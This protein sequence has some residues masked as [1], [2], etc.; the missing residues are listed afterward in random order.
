MIPHDMR[1]SCHEGSI[2]D[3][4]ELWVYDV[5]QRRWITVSL[6]YPMSWLLMGR[7]ALDEVL[8]EEWEKVRD[9]A[10]GLVE[11][12]IDKVVADDIVGINV[13]D[14]GTLTFIN[15]L[16]GYDHNVS[17]YYPPLAEYQLPTGSVK[18]VLRSEITELE[19]LSVHVDLVSYPGVEKGV[20]KYSHHHKGYGPMWQQIHIHARLPKHP[21]ILPLECL[22]LEEVS[23]TRVV[24]FTA[25]FIAGND[26]DTNKDRLFKLKH[27]RQLMQVNGPLL[28]LPTAAHRK[29][30]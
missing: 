27:L 5:D 15:K 21:N 19:R 28:V 12:H 4:L 30:T 8:D 20:F 25:P 11:E 1:F 14:S 22:V 26:L 16:P 2:I 3:D 13:D 6:A 29:L 24:G 18:T 9:K 7:E 17:T 10:Q 23:G